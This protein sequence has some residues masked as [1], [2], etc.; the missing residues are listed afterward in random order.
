[1]TPRNIWIA[2][3]AVVVVAGGLYAYSTRLKP[4]SSGAQLEIGILFP[5][6]GDAASYGVKGRNGIQLA[7]DNLNRTME[8]GRKI[9]A[10]FEDSAAQP[11]TGLSAFQKLSSVDA[12]PAVV[13]DIVSA[14]TLAVAPAANRSKTVLLSPTSSAPNITQ[15][16][17]YV[18][19]IWPSDL[20]EGRAIAEYAVSRG[21]T[22]A[23][24]LYMNNDYGVAIQDIF[25]S[26]F[27][28]D[29][30]KVVLAQSYLQTDQD[31]RSA[32]SKIKTENPDVLYVAGYYA[33]S[34]TIVRQAYDLKLTIP[35][36]GT[37]AIEDPQF[38]HLA[39]AA[40]EGIVYPL[41]TGFDATSSD[42]HV[43]AFVNE[44][45]KRFG[46]TPG[47]VEAQAY[48]AIGVLC[49]AAS[50]MMGQV[51][52]ERLKGAL[53]NFAPFDGVTGHIKFD[54]NGDVVKPVRLRT[55][56]D[57]KFINLER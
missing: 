46:Q 21:Y 55:I 31:F 44:F 45:Q 18:Y 52:G 16:G 28:K 37:T 20:A 19:R 13:G 42:S 53:D 7:V 5:L 25:S 41:A 36:L 49:K 14:V 33:D 38:L 1:M 34:A 39:G 24:I 54:D 43:V 26:V 22:R 32:L 50:S 6:S 11:V 30:R 4:S 23:A 56:R 15:A 17:P 2:V 40:A 3:V 47:W 10:V 57:R 27:S 29:G 8:C 9:G 48:D 51:T 12:V 35:I